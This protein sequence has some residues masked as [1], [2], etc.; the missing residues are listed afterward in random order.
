MKPY[1]AILVG[2]GTMGKRHRARFEACGVKFIAVADNQE[3]FNEITDK[4]T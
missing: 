2:N 3:E 1:N 4:L